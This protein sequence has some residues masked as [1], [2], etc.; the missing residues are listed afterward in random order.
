MIIHFYLRYHSVAGQNFYIKGNIPVLGNGDAS[1]AFAMSYY[2]NDYWYARVDTGETPLSNAFTYSY[3]LRYDDG[4]ESLEASQDRKIEVSLLINEELKVYDTW[5]YAGE[6]QNAL[7]TQPF[8]E[9]LLKHKPL[10]VKQPVVKNPTHTFQV[11]WPLLQEN[12]TILVIGNTPV[13]NNWD[14]HNPVLLSQ[15]DESTLR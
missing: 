15:E 8:Q 5:N 11:K 4:I 7:Y 12:E 3:I 13:L 10:K 9:T 1:Q 6:Y 14:A 2:N